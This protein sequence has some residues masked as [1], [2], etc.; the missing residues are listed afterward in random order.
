MTEN[1]Y[2]ILHQKHILVWNMCD[3]FPKVTWSELMEI[4]QK[5]GYKTNSEKD[6]ACKLAKA[7][8]DSSN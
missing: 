7:K 3:K 2:K 6:E 1:D 5:T 4:V 8:Q